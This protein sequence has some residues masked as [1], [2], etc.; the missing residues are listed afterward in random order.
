MTESSSPA[1]PGTPDP[2]ADATDQTG[3]Q[4]P[5]AAEA[6][7]TAAAREAQQRRTLARHRAL[8]TSLL[9]LM[10]AIV[11]ATYALPERGY[12]VELVQA[13]AKAGF[14]GGLA[15]WFAVTALFRHPLG[16]PIPH[17]AIIPRQKER[18]GQGLGRFVAGHIVTEGEVRRILERLDLARVLGTWLS[19]PENARQAARH[20]VAAFPPLLEAVE[21]GR[22]R[23][24]IR[25]F[26]PARNSDG[27]VAAVIAQGMRF[28]IR[29]GHHQEA[30]SFLLREVKATLAAH[31]EA[32]QSGIESR[33]PW[34]SPRFVDRAVARKIVGGLSE[35]L[36]KVEPADSEVRRRFDD[37]VHDFALEL[38]QNPARRAA[39]AARARRIFLSPEVQGWFLSLW[40]RM[41]ERLAAEAEAPE[42]AAVRFL[43]ESMVRLGG[44]LATRPDLRA[45]VNGTL[46]PALLALLPE[47][48]ARLSGFVAD[49][50]RGW[51]AGTVANRIELAVGKDLQY[52]RING[53]LVGALAGGALFALLHALF[54]SVAH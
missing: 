22:I 36:A 54:G 47:A 14:V 46:G 42:G 20:L 30:F 8:A 40:H 29:D 21:D 16:I 12:W 26:A 41:R 19:R 9:V 18:I 35:A 33:M 2:G 27:G 37:W 43:A 34:Y 50:V 17:T 38:E 15:D 32:L 13:S 49:V 11:A 25:L 5:S 48:Q 31:Q 53:T 1:T 28:L 4:P 51:D 6:E 3:A 23:R 24:V 52:V 10:A 44:L 39:I 7:A 45:R